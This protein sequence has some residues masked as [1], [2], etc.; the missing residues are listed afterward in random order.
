MQKIEGEDQSGSHR[1]SATESK[2][3]ENTFICMPHLWF[4][5]T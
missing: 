1:I 5:W 3:I 4:E 2:T